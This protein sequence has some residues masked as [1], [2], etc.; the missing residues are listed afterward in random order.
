MTAEA[1][2]PRA[3]HGNLAAVEAD[4]ALGSAPAVADAAAT[5]AMRHASELLCRKTPID[6]DREAQK[7][8]NLAVRSRWD[9]GL[10][11]AVSQIVANLVAVITLVASFCWRPAPTRV[12]LQL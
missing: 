8:R 12:C 4:L 7:R 9:D 3:M 2:H 1:A 5:A 6:S 11:A 10:N